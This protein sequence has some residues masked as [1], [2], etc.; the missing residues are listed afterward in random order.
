[1]KII[2]FER[3]GNVVRFY[4]GEDNLSEYWGDDWDDKPY[5]YNAGPVYSE[6]LTKT[7]LAF[8]VYFHIRDLIAEPAMNTS[9]DHAYSKEDMQKEIV[10]CIV[11]GLYKD[12]PNNYYFDS[13][14]NLLGNKKTI[15][16]YFNDDIDKVHTIL[17]DNNVFCK[18]SD[19]SEEEIYFERN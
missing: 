2:D 6:F 14:T 11:I 3:K 4:L 17:R 1:M 13:F 8:D 7:N 9:Y 18:F 15:K 12:F 5:E 10:P 16:I 19:L